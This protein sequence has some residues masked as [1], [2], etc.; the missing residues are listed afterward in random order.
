[1]RHKDSVRREGRATKSSCSNGSGP[2][3]SLH[4]IY[5]LLLP[6]PSG[7]ACCRDFNPG[8]PGYRN[9]T[10]A[11]TRGLSRIPQRYPAFARAVLCLLAGQIFKR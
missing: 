1:M 11:G 2:L 7:R 4:L 8:I 10:R 5:A 9:G 3:Q 6:S